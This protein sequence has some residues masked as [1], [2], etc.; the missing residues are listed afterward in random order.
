VL[1][2]VYTWRLILSQIKL[3][4]YLGVDDSTVN[5]KV[6]FTISLNTLT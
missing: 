3:A 6:T 5:K 2:E 4:A 1:G